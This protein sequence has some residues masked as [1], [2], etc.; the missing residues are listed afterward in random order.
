[1]EDVNNKEAA[2]SVGNDV[3]QSEKAAGQN[4]DRSDANNPTSNLNVKTVLPSK[5]G[6]LSARRDRT[7]VNSA[8]SMSSQRSAPSA[9]SPD[10]I[11][12]S[13]AKPILTPLPQSVLTSA[14]VG[15][16]MSGRSGGRRQVITR[17]S[18]LKQGTKNYLAES[19]VPLLIEGLTQLSISRPEKSDNSPGPAVWLAKYLL[20]RSD[21][22]KDYVLK[23][24]RGGIEVE[25]QTEDCESYPRKKEVAHIETQTDKA[26]G[27]GLSAIR[28]LNGAGNISQNREININIRLDGALL[29]SRTT[30]INNTQQ[31]N[32]QSEEVIESYDVMLGNSNITKIGKE[33]IA[34]IGTNE[35][36][37]EAAPLSQKEDN[38]NMTG[39]Y[40]IQQ[41]QEPLEQNQENEC[42]DL[43]SQ[44]VL[45]PNKGDE[46]KKSNENQTVVSTAQSNF[47]TLGMEK[48]E[49]IFRVICMQCRDGAS[50]SEGLSRRQLQRAVLTNSVQHI[51]SST[52]SSTID[53]AN[54]YPGLSILTKPHRY[55]EGINEIANFNENDIITYTNF[56]HFCHNGLPAPAVTNVIEAK[57]EKNEDLPESK[58]SRET[59]SNYK[60]LITYE[61]LQ[62][63]EEDLSK[64]IERRR[65]RSIV[66][67]HDMIDEI[68][69]SIFNDPKV[70]QNCVRGQSKDKD[71]VQKEDVLF[72][73]GMSPPNVVEEIVD[74]VPAFQFL[75]HLE[76]FKQ[77]LVEYGNNTSD[78]AKASI[79]RIEF[80]QFVKSKIASLN[81]KDTVDGLSIDDYMVNVVTENGNF[82]QDTTGIVSPQ[83]SDSLGEPYDDLAS[84]RVE[85][86]VTSSL[87][88]D[89]AL[90]KIFNTLDAKKDG[91]LD[92]RE[93]L[94]SLSGRGNAKVANLLSY[95]E[96][97][98]ALLRP[99]SYEE[100]F[101]I[102]DTKSSGKVNFDEF[103][104]FC[105][106]VVVEAEEIASTA[107][108]SVDSIVDEMVINSARLSARVSRNLERDLAL[109]TLFRKL[110][111]NMS[112]KSESGDTKRESEPYLSK[113]YV[114]RSLHSNPSI[115][116]WLQNE[117]SLFALAKPQTFGATFDAMNVEKNG[118]V[119]WLEFRAFCTAV[120]LEDE[121]S[122]AAVA[123][124]ELES[125]MV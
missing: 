101:D 47:E 63:L 41:Q 27:S 112:L 20:R 120:S 118:K 108:T 10:R 115:V 102:M 76:Y 58:T 32:N 36:S 82:D 19:I 7:P 26:S 42:D 125:A 9:F 72:L 56:K 110:G 116:E 113:R 53:D 122:N 29:P 84:A 50:V 57:E 35:R 90:K 100:A 28:D 54:M 105:N 109:R 30:S 99:K 107:R 96:P 85:T 51:I 91:N 38:R 8:R 106:A 40:S 95:F 21:Q 71:E 15:G 31:L 103:R 37:L 3:D 117:R 86:N 97:L 2:K 98:Q 74:I 11:P 43:E 12:K 48:T 78:I 89:R 70:A 73:L 24:R 111:A 124:D 104:A 5:F 17:N 69:T 61:E 23:R 114:L 92:K 13:A 6:F 33:D 81:N 18:P 77:D 79:S 60:N 68:F 59:G 44:P 88:L 64:S 22:S 65:P 87:R 45:T 39:D 52:I 4:T 94:T 66:A 62:S 67:I 25:V 123:Q 46:E 14:L 55:R 121:S 80:V 75:L 93:V 83:K 34:N 49:E 1:M 119:S 16:L